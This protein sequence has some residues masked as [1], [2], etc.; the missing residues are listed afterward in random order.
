MNE[1]YLGLGFGNHYYYIGTLCSVDGCTMGLGVLKLTF[2]D[3]V[4]AVVKHLT[5]TLQYNIARYISDFG[6]SLFIRLLF[7]AQLAQF[8]AS[9]PL[10]RSKI[11]HET[12]QKLATL[13]MIGQIFKNIPKTWSVVQ[14]EPSYYFLLL[15]RVPFSCV[16]IIPC[17]IFC[18]SRLPFIK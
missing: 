14:L 9:G 8:Q 4:L 2:G 18:L 13:F 3:E 12:Q 7:L 10:Q 16:A 17:Q 6:Q 15:L 1:F 11:V 5:S